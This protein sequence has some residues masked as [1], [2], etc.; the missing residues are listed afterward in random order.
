MMDETI[1]VNRGKFGSFENISIWEVVVG[2]I[3][4]V[5]PGQRIPADCLVLDSSDFKVDEDA[6]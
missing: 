5:G 3:I 4:L 1:T 6:D 2:D